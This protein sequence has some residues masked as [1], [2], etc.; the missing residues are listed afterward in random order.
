MLASEPTPA[1]EAAWHDATAAWLVAS[2]L[3]A[4][5]DAPADAALY[6]STGVQRLAAYRASEDPICILERDGTVRELS[7]AADAPEAL[8]RRGEKA[9]V[10]LPKEVAHLVGA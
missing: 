9:Y 8:S 3:S 4:P 7:E 6:V 1:D 5:A 10:C 2:G